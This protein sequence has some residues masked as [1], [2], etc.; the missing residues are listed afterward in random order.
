MRTA[1]RTV[2]LIATLAT[3][4]EATEPEPF[5]IAPDAV[6]L[7][8]GESSQLTA[9][10]ASEE[11]VWSSSNSQVATVVSATGFVR[12]VSRGE[13]SISAV[14]GST[15][16]TASVK[17]EIPPALGL[18]SPAANFAT[19]IGDPDPAAQSIIVSNVG[20]RA[21]NGITVGTIAYGENQPTGWLTTTAS[22]STAPVTVSLTAKRGSLPRGTYTAT[23]PIL[24]AGI[25]NSPQHIAVIF[26][27]QVPPSIVVSRSTVPMSG[28]PGTTITE[29]VNVTNGGDAALTG[30]TRTIT[31][32][33]GSSQTWLTA[34]LGGTAAPTSLTLAASTSGLAV[35]NYAATVRVS[36]S[37]PNVAPRDIAVNLTVS[38]GPAIALS[39]STVNVS[40]VFGT[41]P[42]DQ[43]VTVTNS[44]GG[45][46]NQLSLD[47][48]SFG[49]GQAQGWLS[50]IPAL[51][52]ATAPAVI[53]LK[54]ATAS[55]PNGTYNATVPVRSPV[56]SNSPLNLNVVL[57]VSPPPVISLSPTS[58]SFAA[59]GGAATP[60]GA[61]NVLVTNSGGG[62]LSGLAAT[63]QYTSA[64]TGWLTSTFVGGPG[65][66]LQLRPNTTLLNAGLHTATVTVSSNIAG[67]APKTVTVTY[68]IQTFTV[69]VLPVFAQGTTT[70]GS[71]TNC[72]FSGGQSPNL[73]GTANSI[74][75]QV[76]GY[77]IP[78]NPSGSTLICKVAGACAHTGGK[79][80]GTNGGI[81]SAWITAGAPFR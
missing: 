30:L 7:L 69:H 22:G 16:A 15:V 19:V 18:S 70:G 26:S 62:T 43:Q 28:I 64:A 23:V 54:F 48:P 34:T 4:Q 31:Y 25:D 68:T 10:G 32:T 74:Y 24:A 55:L 1:T 21:I 3:C 5:L 80:N 27:V 81:L 47:A 8:V 57:V 46:L 58:V 73:S 50:P 42:A 12:G 71:C 60:P 11:V 61:Q 51:A 17:V 67:V 13:A 49:Q 37:L 40:A 45:T 52:S 66:S 65:V 53:T 63:I 6:V 35:G 39:S 2:L 44:G 41:N 36:S 75:S 76:I 33:Q 29:V 59:W 72:H 78:G 77:V 79:V 20:D 14:S 9:T 38:P 56:A